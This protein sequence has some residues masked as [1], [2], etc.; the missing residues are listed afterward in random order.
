MTPVCC[1]YTSKCF[2]VQDDGRLE[3]F[4]S[5]TPLL[6]FL[7]LLRYSILDQSSTDNEFIPSSSISCQVCLEPSQQNKYFQMYMHM[8]KHCSQCSQYT[9]CIIHNVTK[10]NRSAETLLLIYS[11]FVCCSTWPCCFGAKRNYI[12]RPIVMQASV[13]LQTALVKD[14]SEGLGMWNY[15]VS[16]RKHDICLVCVVMSVNSHA[17]Q[18]FIYRHLS[19]PSLAY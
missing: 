18:M 15:Y 14:R 1:V 10:P 17:T 16:W 11:L 7:F 9:V 19:H 12:R 4:L 8:T 3:G 2:R 13:W 5:P 6:L